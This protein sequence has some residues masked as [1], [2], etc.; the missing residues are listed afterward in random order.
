MKELQER[1]NQNGAVLKVD[2][3]YG[4]LTE[5]AVRA[6]Q[7]EHGL[8]TDG[9]CGEEAWAEI[10]KMPSSVTPAAH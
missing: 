1:L 5:A 8:K 4:R 2:G 7:K 10:E 9:I 6:F 3:K